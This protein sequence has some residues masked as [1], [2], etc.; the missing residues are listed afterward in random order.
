MS[1]LNTIIKNTIFKGIGEVGS[2]V[3]GIIFMVLIARYLQPDGFGKFN[4]VF[5]LVTIFAV[6]LDLGLHALMIRDVARKN[7][8]AEVYIS[9][10]LAMK[11]VASPIIL[12][13]MT[14]VVYFMGKSPEVILLVVI[15]GGFSI[16]NSC[17]ELS[18]SVFNAF[19]KME[20]DMLI[21]L[22][23]KI[24]LLFFGILVL[25]MNLGLIGV[26]FSYLF[27][28]T[29]AVIYGTFLVKDVANIK[30]GLSF[31]KDLIKYLIKE[32]L[33]IAGTM[34][35]MIFYFR[36]GVVLLSYIKDDFQVGLFS[37][38]F[39]IIEALT[40]LPAVLVSAV[41]PVL[42][43]FYKDKKNLLYPA[44]EKTFLF[45]ISF[46]LPLVG[47]FF[48]FSFDII[49]FLYGVKFSE[50]AN[51]LK[52]LIIG[53]IFSFINYFL[54]F[55]LISVNRQNLIIVSASIAAFSSL[56]FNS[57]LISFY[58]YIGASL[59]ESLTE[60]TFFVF[61]LYFIIQY[62]KNSKF[63]IVSAK[64]VLSAIIMVLMLNL[65]KNSSALVN[66]L[67]S[68]SVYIIMVLV[69]GVFSKEDLKL[70]VSKI[71]G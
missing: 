36:I 31:D 66:G 51:A 11:A 21:R 14:L 29:I 40:L 63:L 50:S 65:L 37:A 61:S 64:P 34:A 9:N 13:I 20:Y 10:I 53:N 43:H 41:F 48:F 6:G 18:T 4:F 68:L 25:F 69:L 42:S 35:L 8:I 22:F 33:P 58:G 71:R 12:L 7:N 32:T 49:T 2:R 39:K 28:T 54:Y 67:I 27:S 55:F 26:G 45:I 59:A 44:F 62:L 16:A 1:I 70:V 57:V 52:I 30:M 47:L 3:L 24:F 19:Q 17:M 56:L 38:P 60:L 5:S 15:L 23:N 46:S